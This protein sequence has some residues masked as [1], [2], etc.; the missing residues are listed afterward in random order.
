[1][2]TDKKRSVIVQACLTI[3]VLAFLVL[4][5]ISIWFMNLL[6]ERA[7]EREVNCATYDAR[8]V[9]ESVVRNLCDG[10]LIPVS[11]GECRGDLPQLQ[12]QDV[13]TIFKSNVAQNISTYDDVSEIFGIYEVYCE[14][15]QS[16]F[17]C[18]YDV[19]GVGPR[20]HIFYNSTTNLAE[21]IRESSCGS[22]S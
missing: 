17:R 13:S 2:K 15:N 4:F 9:P 22:G 14:Q 1:M 11:L 19:S 18:T 7:A 6:S 5:A 10:N 3:S 12:L 8:P 16:D 21:S 20:I